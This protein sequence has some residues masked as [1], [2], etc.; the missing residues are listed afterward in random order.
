MTS[1][2]QSA[3]PAML[4]VAL[5]AAMMWYFSGEQSGG[6]KTSKI[7]RVGQNAARGER[8]TGTELRS[9]G[10]ISGCSPETLAARS[11][12]NG[13]AQGS[14]RRGRQVQTVANVRL[15]T[16]NRAP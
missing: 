1:A 6:L 8:Q 7:E 12:D 16:V 4:S 10:T 15:T 11:W 14:G 13:C 5:A 3:A 2:K 9:N